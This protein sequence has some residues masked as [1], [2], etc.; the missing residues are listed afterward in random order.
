MLLNE[1]IKINRALKGQREREKMRVRET[2]IIVSEMSVH[3][4]LILHSFGYSSAS[5]P[6][7]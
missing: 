5:K 4:D 6:P 7:L 3:P 1:N 2:L